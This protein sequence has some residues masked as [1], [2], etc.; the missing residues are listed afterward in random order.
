VK[1]EKKILWPLLY[2][3]SVLQFLVLH[4]TGVTTPISTVAKTIPSFILVAMVFKITPRPRALFIM[5]IIGMNMAG[6]IFLDLDRKSFFLE[7]LISFLIAH[8][9]YIA[10]FLRSMTI[11]I[12][13]RAP[14]LL[15]AVA[16]TVTLAILFSTMNSSMKVPVLLYLAVISSMN[17]IAMINSSL[18]RS[19]GIGAFLFLCSDSIIAITT[20]F[21]P[22]PHSTLVS[23]PLYFVA[24]FVIISSLMRSNEQQRGNHDASISEIA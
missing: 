16:I 22:V 10:L 5:V 24:Q 4:G 21:Y 13:N 18:D 7:G 11:S 14:E 12:K 3:L 9:L 17:I 15:A 20:F 23:I 8:L 2:L 6:D 1:T 19:V